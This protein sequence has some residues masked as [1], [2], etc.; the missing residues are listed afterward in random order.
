MFR[1]FFSI[2]YKEALQIRRDPFTLFLTLVIP[3]F[4]LLIFGYAIDMTVRD[5]KTAVYNLDNRRESWDLIDSFVNTEYFKITR[6]VFSDEELNRLIVSGEVKIGI[7]IP[8]DFSDNLLK[9]WQATVLVLIDGSD[10][11]V[12]SQAVSVVTSVGLRKSLQRIIEN[13]SSRSTALPI[14]VRPKMLFNPDSR[15]ANF[16]VPGLIA[17]ILQIVT[18]FLTALSIVRER[19][20]GR[21][22]NSSLRPLNHSALCL[23]SLFRTVFS[24]F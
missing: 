9:G 8:P 11:T 1:G 12:A 4:Q 24:A 13:Q 16:M 3:M 20:R 17:I 15:S 23:A 6:R 22:N 18:T 10:S 2:V 21:L 14:E 7:K 19:E 5:I